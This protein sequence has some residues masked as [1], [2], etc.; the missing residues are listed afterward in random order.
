MPTPALGLLLAG[1][2]VGVGGQDT[3]EAPVDCGCSG[4]VA[5]AAVV[6]VLVT[7]VLGVLLYFLCRRRAPPAGRVHLCVCV[8]C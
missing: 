1:L 2:L 7:V 3:Q 6:G 8:L 5:A 4:S